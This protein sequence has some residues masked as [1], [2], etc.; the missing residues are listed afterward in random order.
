VRL[1]DYTFDVEYVK[2]EENF[3]DIL[4]VLQWKISVFI[5]SLRRILRLQIF[6]SSFS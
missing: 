6:Y 3:I 5:P 2:G 1:L 4:A